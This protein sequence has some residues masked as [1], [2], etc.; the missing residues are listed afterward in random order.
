MSTVQEIEAALS[1]LPPED[2]LTVERWMA[3]FKKD[4]RAKEPCAD[5]M[6]EYAVTPEELDRFDARMKKEIEADRQE[7]KLR[8]FT[9][10]LD[11]DFED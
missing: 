10:N 6:R 3:Q 5:A 2:F 9:G 11:K 1:R 8:E 7:G 4:L